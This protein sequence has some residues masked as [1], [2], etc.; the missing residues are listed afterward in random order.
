MCLRFESLNLVMSGDI[1]C[2]M[3]S[4]LMDLLELDCDILTPMR[5]LV[6]CHIVSACGRSSSVMGSIG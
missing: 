3:R 5:L 4:S 2:V 1:M 6:P